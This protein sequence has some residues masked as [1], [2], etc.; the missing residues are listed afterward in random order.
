MRYRLIC[1]KKKL[2]L[3]SPRTALFDRKCTS[4]SWLVPAI[5]YYRHFLYRNQWQT[6][7]TKPVS[8]RIKQTI[9]VRFRSTYLRHRGQ[10]VYT[11][12]GIKQH[13]QKVTK[14]IML[15]KQ[16]DLINPSLPYFLPSPFLKCCAILLTSFGR[17][18]SHLRR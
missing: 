17:K 5:T 4:T 13:E 3:L 16:T 8:S 10:I 7:E 9:F 18:G 6:V 15:N 2:F 14:F 12:V 11:G 1:E